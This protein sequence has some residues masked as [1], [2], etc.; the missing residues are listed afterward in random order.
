M[1][2]N[3]KLKQHTVLAIFESFWDHVVLASWAPRQDSETLNLGGVVELVI[4]MRVQVGANPTSKQRTVSTFFRI[5]SGAFC[6]G[7]LSAS[8]GLRSFQFG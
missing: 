4:A 2:P 6:V 3:P 5:V 7:E 1:S 8:R